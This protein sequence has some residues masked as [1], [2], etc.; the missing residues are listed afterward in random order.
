M[1]LKVILYI[2]REFYFLN[3]A[4]T[5]LSCQ[6]FIFLTLKCLPCPRR[7]VG[8]LRWR[9]YL[10]CQIFPPRP[11]KERRTQHK[12]S[13]PN[14]ETC[15]VYVKIMLVLFLIDI[16]CRKFGDTPFVKE[17]RPIVPMILEV[18]TL[19]NSVNLF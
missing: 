14:I 9:R 13:I 7:G 15:S 10:S 6:F 18:T 1:F 19:D 8:A 2:E 3:T 17:T 4:N 16:F 11:D 12:N 5:L